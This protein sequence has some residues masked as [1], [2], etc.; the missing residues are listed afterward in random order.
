MAL[1][2]RIHENETK[3]TKECDLPASAQLEQELVHLPRRDVVELLINGAAKP[4]DAIIQPV[5]Q[6]MLNPKNTFFYL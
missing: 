6:R 5:E 1:K 4:E 2:D 3:K